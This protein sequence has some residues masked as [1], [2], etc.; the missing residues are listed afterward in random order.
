MIV[1][2]AHPPSACLFRVFA[3]GPLLSLR[4]RHD[5]DAAIALPAGFV[6]L[7]A[8]GALF[9]VANHVE[10]SRGDADPNQIVL[11]GAGTPIAKGDVVIGEA[12]LAARPSMVRW[13]CCILQSACE[14]PYLA[15]FPQ[16]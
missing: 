12:A 6:V 1:L 13:Q 2:A 10:L 16:L 4:H 9:T 8:D 14:L 3:R 5:V 7:L 15:L 11:R